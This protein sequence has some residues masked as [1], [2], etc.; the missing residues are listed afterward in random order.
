M[1]SA[2]MLRAAVAAG[3]LFGMG[4]MAAGTASAI[5]VV[6]GGVTS[7]ILELGKA[8]TVLSGAGVGITLT[9]SASPYGPDVAFPV[10][11]GDVDLAF[12]E[13]EILHDGSGVDLSNGGNTVK[14]SNLVVDLTNLLI[15]G[16]VEI[17]IGGVSQGAAAPTALFDLT[18]CNFSGALDPCVT[19]S[20]S[21]RLDGYGARLTAGAT[22]A[23]A[24][25]LGL[26]ATQ[27]AALDDRHLV[28]ARLDIALVPEPGTALLL[29][30]GLVGLAT[31]RGRKSA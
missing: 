15:R 31:A 3:F 25:A 9:G 14:L 12:L 24:S 11:G 5:P 16:D 17:L 4:G 18:I 26:D 13:G 23:L 21:I 28:I 1:R 19:D 10:T 27:E 22:A 2:Q 29:A 7:T 6:G 8:S 20:D 30:A